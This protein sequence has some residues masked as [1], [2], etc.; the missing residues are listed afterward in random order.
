M[1][2]IIKITA[3]ISN[4]TYVNCLLTFI[5]D[6][7]DKSFG[8]LFFRTELLYL[9]LLSFSLRAFRD[10]I[11]SSHATISCNL[12]LMIFRFCG[13]VSHSLFLF[14]FL[15]LLLLFVANSLCRDNMNLQTRLLTQTQ[16]HI[17]FF[18]SNQICAD[19]CTG[20]I[21]NFH[22]TRNW[23]RMPQITISFFCF[24]LLLSL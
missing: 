4:I 19:R 7:N 11:F 22:H 12:F 18:F 24:L 14:F 1:V 20:L 6:T 10:E 3:I 16:M 15:F 5:H 23:P 21:C 2:L 17:L 9:L 13:W 8:F